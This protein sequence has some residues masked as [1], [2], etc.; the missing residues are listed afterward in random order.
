[1]NHSSPRVC[2][3]ATYPRCTRTRVHTRPSDESN[4]THFLF[5]FGARAT[6][7]RVRCVTNAP[8]RSI[9]RAITE[10][11][12][13]RFIPFLRFYASS[14][15]SAH[16]TNLVR[17][18]RAQIE[19]STRSADFFRR[20][21]DCFLSLSLSLSLSRSPLSCPSLRIRREK[22]AHKYSIVRRNGAGTG[23]LCLAETRFEASAS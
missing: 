17:S 8:E 4:E 9:G 16:A 10:L 18:P 20:L 13:H 22:R 23:F 6:C 11:A 21:R 12:E 3:R 2:V 19:P 7:S 1:M 14:L 15:S 5:C